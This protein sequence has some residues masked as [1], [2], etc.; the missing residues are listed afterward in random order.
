MET[1]SSVLRERGMSVLIAHS[2]FVCVF[3]AE[4]RGGGNDCLYLLKCACHSFCDS[5]AVWC[6]LVLKV[7]SCRWETVCANSVS[8]LG[9]RS[10]QPVTVCMH[11][12]VCAFSCGNVW[13]E[14]WHG[15]DHEMGDDVVWFCFTWPKAGNSTAV[16]YFSLN[17]RTF[18][19][20]LSMVLCFCLLVL[21]N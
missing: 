12:T 17:A 3:V 18:F 6:E 10:G 2:V 15:E 4:S 11:V 20:M 7:H 5:L 19:F 1:V 8:P 9:C 14:L 21:E 13:E 16:G